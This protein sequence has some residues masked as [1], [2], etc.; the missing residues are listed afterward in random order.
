[1]AK[2]AMMTVRLTPE[3]SEK[4]EALARDTK[5]SK[6]YLASEAI[7]SYVTRNA[8]Q[9]AHIRA[10]LAEDEEGA[11]GVPHEEVMRWMKSWGTDRK[12]PRPEPKKS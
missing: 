4:L 2:S 7:E 12:L 11:P 10:A 1:M 8:W 9:V 3:L 5:R 6:S